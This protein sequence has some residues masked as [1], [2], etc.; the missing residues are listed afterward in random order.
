MKGKVINIRWLDNSRYSSFIGHNVTQVTIK[1]I[2]YASSIQLEPEV[3][4][5]YKDLLKKLKN[6][7]N[8]ADEKSAHPSSLQQYRN[9]LSAL[10]SYLALSGKTLDANI[11]VELGS[12][13]DELLKAY[14]Q[15]IQVSERTK[16]DRHGQLR[17]LR[18]MYQ[19]L[20][21]NGKQPEQKTT[22]FTLAL[23]NAVANTGIAPKTL[24]K[25][26]GINPTT[27]SRWLSGAELNQRG[28]AS[29]H[30][31]ELGLSME[32]GALTTLLHSSEKEEPPLKTP[33]FRQRLATLIESSM[34]V[35]EAEL[36]QTFVEE[37]HQLFAY[38]VGGYSQLRRTPK[39]AWRLIP[40]DTCMELSPLVTRR[41]MA[42]PTGY[43]TLSKL[44]S[45]LGVLQGLPVC[46]GGL[47][48]QHNF[49]QTLAWLALPEALSIYLEWLTDR[50]D[51]IRH[52]GQRVFAQTIASLVRPNTGYLWQQP[53]VFRCK[54]PDEFRPPTD[55]AWQDMCDRSHDYL[56]DFI[57][58]CQGVS[59]SPQEPIAALLDSGEPLKPLLE[60]I[61]RIDMAAAKCRPGS[62]AEALHK[63]NA[64]LLAFLVSNPLRQRTIASLTWFPFGGGS[65]RGS[66]ETGWRIALGGLQQKNGSSKRGRNYDVKVADWVKPRLEAYLEEYRE[67]LLEGKQSN[68]LFVSSRK[69]GIWRDI[70]KTVIKL[71]RKYIPG[72]PGF[73]PHAVRHLVATDWLRRYPGEFLT[74][75]ELLNDRL[76]TVLAEYAHLKR[77]DSFARYETHVLR[78]M[79]K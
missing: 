6:H 64:L 15:T 12:R 45:F 37:W 11:G 26:V 67:T 47:S 27:L 62:K 42:S 20:V 53:Q 36:S 18:R 50:S 70:T 58:T 19:E 1:P 38:K 35:P 59:R 5:S 56:R 73:G 76:E 24:A 39:G 55:E 4:Y 65:L 54:L 10:N 68:Y 60:A 29:L 16:Q 69:E 79:D 71:T 66:S 34:A 25:Q 63:R 2:V 17:A 51:G 30:R 61:N 48:S 9:H 21:A 78:L 14:L 23:R 72:C 43:M 33:S 57:R 46:E 44:R 40:T 75:A 52:G 74:V 13:F 28:Y 32:R 7:F 31:L 49:I 77:D 41:N 8:I 3:T 22:S